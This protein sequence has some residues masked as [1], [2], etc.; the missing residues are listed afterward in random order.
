MIKRIQIQ[1][2]RS[3]RNT[4]IN[5]TD[6]TVIVGANA[7]GKS[8]L[9]KGIEFLSDLANLGLSETIYKRG[10]FSEIIPKMFKNP[11]SEIIKFSVELNLDPPIN[12][13]DL[14]LP[15]LNVCY[16]V[17]ITQTKQKKI[18]ITEEH[19]C[20][21]HCLLNAFFLKE[22]YHL[23]MKVNEIPSIPNYLIGSDIEFIRKD[24]SVEIKLHFDIND[25]NS[26]LFA[27][28]IGSE[29]FGGQ[30][31]V[32]DKSHLTSIAEFLINKV[33]PESKT[34]E[35]LIISSERYLEGFSVHF[36]R[37]I[38]EI[39]GYSKYDLLINELRQEQSISRGIKVSSSGDNVPSV[40]KVLGQK[41]WADTYFRILNTMS[42]ISP[43]FN[44]VKSKSL[45]A[46]KEYVLFS[47]IFGGRDI[48]AWESS[49]GTLRAYAIL[50]S[51]ETHPMG[52]TVMIEEPEHGLHPWAIKDLISH[53]RETIKERNI[54][55]ILTT[56]SQQVLEC[57]YPNEL[58]I[59]DRTT[60]GTEFNRIK[61]I[62]NEKN[63][64]MGEIGDLWVRGLLKGVPINQ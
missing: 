11:S 42:N 57:I 55:I 10:G 22:K 1:N 30:N 60:K 12:W 46:G 29:V 19:L 6:L 59:A 54:Q 61:D 5:L 17:G 2:F 50:L 31:K 13:T 39:G 4:D 47:E 56:H 63:V 36:R 32:F 3:I 62:L 58:L 41:G 9:I 45:R 24:G 23:K 33:K 14:N 25:S 18:L 52:S 43:Y 20:I 38:E 49:D 51:I 53:M 64:S 37:V 16:T 26:V 28:W 21:R 34:Q 35:E 44:S 40:T 8:N 15:E 48:E 27:E 7:T